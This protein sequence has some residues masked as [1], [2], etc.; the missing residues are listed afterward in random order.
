MRCIVRSRFQDHNSGSWKR[1]K[2]E[3]SKL[4]G[5]G[6]S[7]GSSEDTLKQSRRRKL[8]SIIT[9]FFLI[10]LLDSFP[11]NLRKEQLARS[12]IVDQKSHLCGYKDQRGRRRINY[13]VNRFDI[14]K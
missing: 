8:N 1:S 2:E 14:Q 6:G 3:K 10:S 11:S 5:I 9:L 13:Y 4:L 7:L 12:T